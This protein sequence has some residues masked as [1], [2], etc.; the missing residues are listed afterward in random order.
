MIV[1]EVKNISKIL[2]NQKMRY[3]SLFRC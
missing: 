2:K 3:S 1:L